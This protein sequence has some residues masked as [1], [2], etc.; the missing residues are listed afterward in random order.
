MLANLETGAIRPGASLQLD[1][2]GGAN[3]PE[4]ARGSFQLAAA[5]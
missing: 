2:R 1:R 5:R 4:I 3:C